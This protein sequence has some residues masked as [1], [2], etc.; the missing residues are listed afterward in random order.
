MADEAFHN[1]IQNYYDSVLRSDR[2]QNIVQSGACSQYD[3]REVFRNNIEKRVRFVALKIYS[4][5]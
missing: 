2:I 1:A 5:T 3:L 4:Q